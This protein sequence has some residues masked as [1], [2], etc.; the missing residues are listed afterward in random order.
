[1]SQFHDKAI[2]FS[3][4]FSQRQGW[5]NLS[6]AIV[7]EDIMS[8]RNLSNCNLLQVIEG[9]N[10]N[11]RFW[12]ACIG[13]NVHTECSAREINSDIKYDLIIHQSIK[14]SS[15]VLESTY[16]PLDYLADGGLYLLITTDQGVMSAFEDAK[17]YNKLSNHYHDYKKAHDSLRPYLPTLKI[18]DM[19]SEGH[20]I[21]WMEKPDNDDKD[22]IIFATSCHANEVRADSCR[23]TWIPDLKNI[24]YETLIVIGNPSQKDK[25]VLTDDTL[26]VKCPDTYAALPVKTKMITEYFIK[27]CDQKYMFKCDDDTYVRADT[28]DSY[29]KKDLEYI[30]RVINNH[31]GVY[32]SGGAGYFLN[33]KAASLITFSDMPEYGYEDL[34]VGKYLMGADI[35]LYDEVTLLGGIWGW[36]DNKPTDLK[37]I[38]TMIS[39]HLCRSDVEAMYNLHE[40]VKTL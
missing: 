4:M 32:A 39:Q 10:D 5:G 40:I 18:F 27:N 31:R 12:Q 7:F 20:K 29:D 19:S 36:E 16:N 35:P 3:P 9:G 37:Y 22:T 34:L 1:M 15:N 6:L 26:F 38:R 13:A 11:K 17:L 24:G 33:K 30:G 28:F 21:L 23:D 2:Q 25:F 14:S 8:T